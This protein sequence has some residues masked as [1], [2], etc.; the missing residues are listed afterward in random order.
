MR[1]VCRVPQFDRPFFVV[2]SLSL[3]LSPVGLTVRTRPRSLAHHPPSLPPSPLYF[4]QN[5]RI[6]FPLPHRIQRP[7][8]KSLRGV[9]KAVRPNTYYH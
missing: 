1:F 9:Y 2:L 3:V 5:S 4:S 8:T 6:K 7:P